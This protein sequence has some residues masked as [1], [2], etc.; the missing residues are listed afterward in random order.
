MPS[1][2]VSEC[3]Y[4]DVLSVQL[5]V[6]FISQFADGKWVPLFTSMMHLLLPFVDAQILTTKATH[7]EP[8]LRGT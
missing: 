8:I 3:H 5:R 6:G 7:Q 1:G 2:R 4:N